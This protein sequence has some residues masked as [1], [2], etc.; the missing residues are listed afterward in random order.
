[1]SPLI[2]GDSKDI[3]SK[4]PVSL[5]PKVHFWKVKEDNQVETVNPGHLQNA[6]QNNGI[7][8]NYQPCCA[9]AQRVEH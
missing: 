1:M 3:R 6:H 9:V 5:T 4:T 8:I 2:S 7:I